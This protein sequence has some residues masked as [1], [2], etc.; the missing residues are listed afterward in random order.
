LIVS[1]GDSLFYNRALL[2]AKSTA[3]DDRRKACEMLEEY[4][5]RTSPNSA[6][7]PL[8]YARYTKLGEG[9]NIKTRSQAKFLRQP[10]P[11]QY[12]VV[13]SVTVGQKTVTLS[14]PT[15]DALSRLDKVSGDPQLLFP[16]GNITRWRF[17]DKGID[18]LGEDKVLAIFLTNAKA[19]PVQ[20]R[21]RG[22]GGSADELKVG[23]SESLAKKMLKDQ[24]TD[25]GQR[26]VSDSKITFHFYPEIGIA[27][28]YEKSRVH[29]IAIA[30]LPRRVYGE[31]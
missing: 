17:V 20:L 9:L 21:Q 10:S 31:K 11:Q 8:A 27:V 3:A 23:M 14:E 25:S 16:K 6:W 29:E 18:V 5:A 26:G 19:P 24:R 30:Q 22:I 4:L 12:R 2:L 15:E 28:R 1:L 13:T 7:W